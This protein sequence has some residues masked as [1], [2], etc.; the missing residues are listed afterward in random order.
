M[1]S[2][3]V[4]S[5][6]L[7]G[8]LIAPTSSSA[9]TISLTEA[10]ALEQLAADNPRVR[11]LNAPVDV[12][13]AD[14]LAARRWPNPRFT[15]DRESVAGVTENLTMV[16]QVLPV[17]GRRTFE[18]NAASALVEA[19]SGLASQQVRRLRTDLRLAFADLVAAQ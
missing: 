11:A 12:A 13:R 2:Q 9:Q 19:A 7:A 6:V 15:Y 16:G 3:F 18:I 14:V 8:L 17:T 4:R 5:L 1:R 10:Q